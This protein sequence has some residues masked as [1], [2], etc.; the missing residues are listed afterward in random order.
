MAPHA[1]CRNRGNRCK[2][3]ATAEDSTARGTYRARQSPRPSAS[4]FA[5]SLEE[6]G[7][8]RPL[9]YSLLAATFTLVSLQPGCKLV[10]G[11]SQLKDD[12][13]DAGSSPPAEA[14]DT[15]TSS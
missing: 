7:H 4:A 15:S 3:R 11:H 12:G 10:G 2:S 6:H 8:M 5:G 1:V 14:S 9:R 13:D